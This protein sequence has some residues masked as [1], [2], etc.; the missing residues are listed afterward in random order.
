MNDKTY[1]DHVAEDARLVILRALADE[2]DRSAND[3]LLQLHLDKFG[4]RKSRDYVKTQL[5]ALAELGA[6]S[7]K[8]AGSVLVATISQLGL[9]HIELRAII[10]GIARPSPPTG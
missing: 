2:T 8:E 7:I 1:S 4:Y 6:V 3:K 10:D 5:R 9:D